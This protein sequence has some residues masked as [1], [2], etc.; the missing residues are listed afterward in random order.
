[1]FNKKLRII[2]EDPNF[3]QLSLDLPY[4]PMYLRTI[5]FCAYEQIIRKGYHSNGAN[6]LP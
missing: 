6:C 2:K 4:L 3:S 1:M 5:Y